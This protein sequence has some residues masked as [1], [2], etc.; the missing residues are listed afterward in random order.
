MKSFTL[1]KRVCP[2]RRSPGLDQDPT[3]VLQHEQQKNP[4]AVSFGLVVSDR[5]T[6]QNK[7]DEQ[8]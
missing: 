7:Y 2:V 3:K 5:R 4:V 6:G 8:D 1:V